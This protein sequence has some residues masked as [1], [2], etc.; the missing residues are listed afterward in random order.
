MPSF[1]DKLRVAIAK[2]RLTQ[3]A[4]AEKLRI[5]QQS[6]AHY[7]KLT[8]PPKDRTLKW[9]AEELNIPISELVSATKYAEQPER[10]LST[11]TGTREMPPGYREEEPYDEA[12]REVREHFKRASVTERNLIRG[13]LGMIITNKA[14]L[15]KLLEWLEDD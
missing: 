8:K 2:R 10:I 6:F 7:L 13:A 4:A 5:R 11:R 3:E 15:V 12:M 14:Q 1:G 9:L